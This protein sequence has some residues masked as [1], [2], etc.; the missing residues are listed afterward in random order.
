[1]LRQSGDRFLAGPSEVLVIADHTA[2]PQ[3]IAADLLAQSE[4][5]REAKGLLITTDRASGNPF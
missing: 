2:D 5:D 1:M 4:H 3:V